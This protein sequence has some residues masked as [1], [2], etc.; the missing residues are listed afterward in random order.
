MT[1]VALCWPL[2]PEGGDDFSTDRPVCQ[3]AVCLRPG[4]SR[5][6]TQDPPSSDLLQASDHQAF[7]SLD[8]WLLRSLASL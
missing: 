2:D 8:P 1:H 3:L 4:I 6:V 7:S 5:R